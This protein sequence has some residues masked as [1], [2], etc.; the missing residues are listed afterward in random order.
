MIINLLG[1]FNRCTSRQLKKRKRGAES[2][3]ELRDVR[4]GNLELNP[5]ACSTNVVENAMS[6]GEEIPQQ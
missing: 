3:Y 6:S 5:V 2:V 1:A 4:D